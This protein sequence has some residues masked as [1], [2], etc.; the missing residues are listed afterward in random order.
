MS[1]VLSCPTLNEMTR[2]KLCLIGICGANNDCDCVGDASSEAWCP[3]SPRPL[4]SWAT[5]HSFKSC[6]QG[7]INKTIHPFIHPMGSLYLRSNDSLYKGQRPRTPKAIVNKITK[8]SPP[9]NVG[10]SFWA[11]P[12]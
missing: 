5:N 8:G 2:C 6:L 12:K 3:R 7:R 4:V 9:E 11:L 10:Q 1:M